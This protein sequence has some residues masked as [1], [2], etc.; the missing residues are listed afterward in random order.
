ME[1]TTIQALECHCRYLINAINEK[2]NSRTLKINSY[3][4][5]KHYF[6]YD[7]NSFSLWM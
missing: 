3:E 4:N 6:F 7:T 1:T 5:K 2:L